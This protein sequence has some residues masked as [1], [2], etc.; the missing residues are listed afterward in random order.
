[1]QSF[2]TRQRWHSRS[3]GKGRIGPKIGWHRDAKA[4]PTCFNRASV[5]EPAQVH[6]VLWDQLNSLRHVV[7]VYLLIYPGLRSLFFTASSLRPL[8]DKP[9]VCKSQSLRFCF[10]RPWPTLKAAVP[11]QAIEHLIL[12]NGEACF[13]RDRVPLGGKFLDTE[14][15][16][17]RAYTLDIKTM[18]KGQ[19]GG[20]SRGSRS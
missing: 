8:P 13:Q 1:M 6:S 7:T 14:S 18:F 4:W 9:S 11:T 19:A 2:D 12:P 15:K 17:G 20:E 10:P 3:V 5:T 16:L